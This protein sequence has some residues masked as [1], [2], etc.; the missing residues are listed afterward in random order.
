MKRCQICKKEFIPKSN[1][2][3]YCS[4]ACQKI[5][6]NFYN[7]SEANNKYREKIKN[8]ENLDDTDFNF[9]FREKTAAN[10][11]MSTS[12]YNSYLEETKARKLNISVQKLRHY[13][14]IAKKNKTKLYE[15]LGMPPD[16]YYS[17]L[18]RKF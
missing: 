3:K 17:M 15:E 7:T 14:Y 12:E 8:E 5:A 11:G 4:S 9:K 18:K 1:N 10:K 13:T 6:R 2:Q 16:L